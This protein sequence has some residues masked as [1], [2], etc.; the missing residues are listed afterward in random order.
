VFSKLVE[1]AQGS[2]ARTSA[3]ATDAAGNDNGQDASAQSAGGASGGSAAQA[4]KSPED[5][6]QTSPEHEAPD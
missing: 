6:D 3:M 4:P 2:E 5:W 1:F